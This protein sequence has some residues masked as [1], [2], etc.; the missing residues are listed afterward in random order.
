MPLQTDPSII[1]ALQGRPAAGTATSARR[2]STSSRP[3]TPTATP[4]LPPGPIGSPGREAILAVLEPA[5]RRRTLYF[6]SRNDGTH[7]FSETLVEH[8][9]AVNRYQRRRRELLSHGCPLARRLAAAPCPAG[10]AGRRR[11]D[12]RSPGRRSFSCSSTAGPW[13]QP[14]TFPVPPAWLFRGGL[15]LAG[16]AFR[17]RRRRARP[18]SASRSRRLFA[19][20]AAGALFAAVVRRHGLDG[21]AVDR[22]AA[23]ARDDARRRGAGVVRRGRGGLRRGR[24][25]PAPRPRGRRR[26]SR[27][28]RARRPAA[29]PRGG[30]PAHDRGPRPRPGRRRPRALATRRG[31]LAP[32]LGR[33]PALLLARRPPRSPRPCRRRPWGPCPARSRSLVSPAKGALVFAPVALVGIVGL[34]RALRPPARRGSGTSR[35]PAASCRSPAGSRSWPTSLGSPSSGAGRPATS[36]GRASSRPPGRSCSCSCP[37]ASRFSGSAASLL[38]VASP[39]PSRRSGPSPTTGG[40]TGSAAPGTARRAGRERPRR[41]GRGREPDPLPGPRARRAAVAPGLDG[42]RLVVRERVVAPSG[43]VQGSF[44]SLREGG[45]R[46]DGCRRDDVGRPPRGRR[47]RQSRTGSS[48]RRA[49]RRPR[50]SAFPRARVRGGSRCGSSAAGRAPSASARSDFWK[51]DALARAGGLRSL[52]P[53]PAV[54]L[55]GVGRRGPGARAPRGRPGLD[56]VGRPG[57]A[58]RAGRRAAPALTPTIHEAALVFLM[59]GRNAAW[60]SSCLLPLSSCQGRQSFA[61]ACCLSSY[62]SRVRHPGT[63]AGRRP[64][65]RGHQPPP[66][67]QRRFRETILGSRVSKGTGGR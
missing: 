18:W 3:T 43:S 2:T 28:G 66:Y 35:S 61:L 32:R 29:R 62:S 37:R 8:N 36:G 64:A 25:G 5:P 44:L 58:D 17:A 67:P 53:A 1:Y 9:R 11:D 22:V 46:A 59:N 60:L 31:L 55:R 7:Q 52:P 20:L 23:R 39:S 65:R 27:P 38:V 54:L 6:V 45:L 4:G 24:G 33:C 47:A 49:G 16:L 51:R 40:G 48:C 26:R 42:R 50:A 15:A 12:R 30:A 34:L 41:V 56:R 63:T 14:R 13:A 57:P 21:G 10:R 19:A